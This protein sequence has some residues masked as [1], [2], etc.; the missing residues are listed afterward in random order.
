MTFIV[1]ILYTPRILLLSLCSLGGGKY[2]YLASLCSKK[3]VFFFVF[4]F[5]FLFF[6]HSN[7]TSLKSLGTLYGALSIWS[8]S[9]Y[10]H[11]DQR[12]EAAAA[13]SESNY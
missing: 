6:Y 11:S 9:I 2:K 8:L 13:R 4:F 10:Y 5:V 12:D 3:H 7:Y 1:D